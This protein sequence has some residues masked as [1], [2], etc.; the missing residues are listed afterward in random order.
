MSRPPGVWVTGPSR[1]GTSMTAGLF[2]AHGVFWGVPSCERNYPA[3][4]HNPKGYFEHGEI[5]KRLETRDF[6]DW[7]EAWWAALEADGWDGSTPWGFK[8]GP[9]VWPWVKVLEPSVIV[10]T[11]R[12]LKQIAA[13]RKRWIGKR[14]ISTIHKTEEKIRAILKEAHCPVIRVNTARMVRSDWSQI[15]LAFDVLGVRFSDTIA[16]SWI[17]PDLWNRGKSK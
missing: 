15:R 1:T 12:P 6:S 9:R 14:S 11:Q 8:R 3:D 17:D 4:E 16:E 7:P 13:S 10:V 2:A 5:T